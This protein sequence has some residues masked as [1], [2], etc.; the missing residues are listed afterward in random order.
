M[1]T[2][3]IPSDSLVRSFVVY[4]IEHDRQPVDIIPEIDFGTAPTVDPNATGGSSS[5]GGSGGGGGGGGA[6]T[7]PKSGIKF[8]G[9]GGANLGATLNF[10]DGKWYNINPS[11]NKSDLSVLGGNTKLAHS[12]RSDIDE[13]SLGIF[14]MDKFASGG[15]ADYTGP[16][17]LDGS[18][19]MPERILSPYQT[20]L[21]E[22][23]V[24]ALESASRI[25]V[26][27]APN[28]ENLQT[29]GSNV[30]VG[31]IIVNVDNLDTDDDYEELAEK[32]GEVLMDKLGRTSVVGGIRIRSI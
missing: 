5:G 10:D 32:V 18:A 14:Q 29:T 12:V 11:L 28:F 30:S 31:D 15:M 1:I 21:F 4:I 20:E 9:T 3:I 26:Q 22:T 17:W 24:H 19:T 25:N 6:D 8:N 23:M 7:P 2:Q 13:E 16:A 27:T